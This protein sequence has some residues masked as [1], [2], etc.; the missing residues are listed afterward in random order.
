MNYA[1]ANVP[2][3][4][5]AKLFPNFLRSGNFIADIIT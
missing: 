2:S 3:T 1:K 4:K 5:L